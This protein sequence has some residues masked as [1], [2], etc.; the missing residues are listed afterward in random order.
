MF[1]AVLSLACR[2]CAENGTIY[3]ADTSAGGA[4]RITTSKTL[5]AL[6]LMRRLPYSSNA[7]VFQPRYVNFVIKRKSRSLGSHRLDCTDRSIERCVRAWITIAFSVTS[8][9]IRR[10]K[11]KESAC[12]RS[13]YPERIISIL[14]LL[15][16]ILTYLFVRHDFHLFPNFW[17]YSPNLRTMKQESSDAIVYPIPTLKTRVWVVIIRSRNGKLSLQPPPLVGPRML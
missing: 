6:Y 12:D 7:T 2:Y 13:Y 11:R 10:Q 8:T 9:E 3:C 4:Y 15:N 1:L 16:T 14:E 17:K 5:F